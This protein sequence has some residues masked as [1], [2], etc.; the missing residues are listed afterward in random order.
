MR[1]DLRIDSVNVL[2]MDPV[3]PVAGSIGVWKGLVVALD[4]DAAA[5]PAARVV[6][7]AGATVLPGFNDA[8]T[9]LC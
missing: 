7:A 1:L 5:L 6:D 2:T 4:G 3:H 9:H 8:H